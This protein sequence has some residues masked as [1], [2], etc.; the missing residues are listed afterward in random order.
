MQSIK[1]HH[2]T[3]MNS[4][5]S[6]NSEQSY[7]FV[8]FDTEAYLVCAIFT[9]SFISEV[10]FIIVELFSSVFLQFRAS[11]T[12]KHDLNFQIQKCDKLRGL[13]DN[14]SIP[15]TFC[16]SI[17]FLISYWEESQ[18]FNSLSRKMT[19]SFKSSH[20]YSGIISIVDI[21][22]ILQVLHFSFFQRRNSEVVEVVKNTCYVNNCFFIK[23]SFSKSTTSSNSH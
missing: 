7:D 20:I 6:S 9:H 23:R 8:L 12:Q 17:S 14:I 21:H 4:I 11:V 19:F 13:S 1:T 15:H 10:Y 22:L 16:S 2:V 18:L 3:H 5:G